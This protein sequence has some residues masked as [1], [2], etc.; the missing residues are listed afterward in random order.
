MHRTC[1]LEELF[2]YACYQGKKCLNRR[3][4]QTVEKKSF[5]EN[6]TFAVDTGPNDRYWMGIKT[7]PSHTLTN[8]DGSP[9]I[10]FPSIIANVFHPTDNT[11]ECMYFT[12]DGGPK[13]SALD[14]C[15]V[16][17]MGYICR[18]VPSILTPITPVAHSTW[19]EAPGNGSSIVVR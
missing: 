7:D 12:M 6:F 11:R 15:H 10:S 13:I 17:K 3:N 19:T 2:F 18:Y 8:L 16:D 14:R 4:K 9:H 5:K 1:G